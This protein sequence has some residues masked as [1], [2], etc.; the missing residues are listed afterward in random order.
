MTVQHTTW[1]YGRRV[2]YCPFLVCTP[3]EVDQGQIAIECQALFK[4]TGLM[5]AS[6]PEDIEDADDGDIL[7]VVVNPSGNDGPPEAAEAL[8]ITEDGT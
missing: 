7:D 3:A 5:G 2:H 6:E 8:E 4:A 1:R